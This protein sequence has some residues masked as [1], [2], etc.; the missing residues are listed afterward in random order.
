[1]VLDEKALE[2]ALDQLKKDGTDPDRLAST[3]AYLQMR[4]DKR[5]QD[6]SGANE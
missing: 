2:R 4:L 6:K 3:R 1:V 5:A